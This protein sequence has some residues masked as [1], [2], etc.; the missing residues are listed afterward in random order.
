MSGSI[1]LLGGARSGKSFAAE[2][3]AGRAGRVHGLNVST[4]VTAE[5]LDAEMSERIFQH[6]ERRPAGWNVIEAPIHLADGVAAAGHNDVLIVDC[7]T[8]WLS[9]KLIKGESLES[10]EK[11]ARAVAIGLSARSG[12]TIVVSNEVGLGIVPEHALGRRFRDLQGRVNRLLVNELDQAYLVV[13]GRL[14]PLT[15]D[16]WKAA[17]AFLDTP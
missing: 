9:N 17:E 11:S 8:V 6:R 16:G 12:P 13:S 15:D 14:V 1:L 7:I 3:L 10:I 5:A 4:V 2:K